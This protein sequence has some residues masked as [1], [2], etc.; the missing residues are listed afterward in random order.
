LES[1]NRTIVKLETSKAQLSLN[2]SIFWKGNSALI[3]L[4]C[5]KICTELKVVTE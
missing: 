5:D 3:L 1:L 4:P 2:S